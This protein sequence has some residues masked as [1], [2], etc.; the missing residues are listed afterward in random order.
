MRQTVE[1]GGDQRVKRFRHLERLDL[2]DGPVD[3]AFLDERAA[4]EQHPH[5]L[6]CVERN[7]L[8]AGEDLLAQ[9]L[10]QAGNETAQQLIH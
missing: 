4:V 6:D 2:A 5:R 10:R 8:G 7:A 3:R 9:R 1:A